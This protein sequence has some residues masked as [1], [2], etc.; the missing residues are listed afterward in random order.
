MMDARGLHGLD[1]NVT[2][3]GGLDGMAEEAQWMAMCME[4]LAWMT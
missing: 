4:T 2:K 3:I 1:E